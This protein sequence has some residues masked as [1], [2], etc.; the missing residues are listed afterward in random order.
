[1]LKSSLDGLFR[2][3][4]DD[5]ELME[6]IQSEI[7]P[8]ILVEEPEDPSRSSRGGPHR[9]QRKRGL[10]SSKAKDFFRH[11]NDVTLAHGGI[12][13]KSLTD[14]TEVHNSAV[15]ASC[16]IRAQNLHTLILG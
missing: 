12:L 3:E 11:V 5:A 4:E 8:F 9:M 2:E 14:K 6:K 10:K 15:T 7:R 13:R 1:M 16:G